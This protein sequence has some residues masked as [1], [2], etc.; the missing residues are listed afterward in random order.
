MEPMSNL[1]GATMEQATETRP[2]AAKKAA[3]P[4]E[5]TPVQPMHADC[6]RL[7][8]QVR[9]SWAVNIPAAYTLEDLGD[10]RVWTHAGMRFKLGDWVEA[11]HPHWVAL[12]FVTDF[13]GRSPV[14]T[15]MCSAK[16]EDTLGANR[17]RFM[18]PEGFTIRMARPGESPFDPETHWLAIRDKDGVILNRNTL[19]GSYEDAYRELLSSAIFLHNT[20]RRRPNPDTYVTKGSAE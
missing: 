16:L 20:P 10:A 15:I 13:N 5:R 2:K 3:A 4:A 9:Q 1:M 8:E 12:G 17:Q 7:A 19:C 11:R 14:I 6:S 18:I